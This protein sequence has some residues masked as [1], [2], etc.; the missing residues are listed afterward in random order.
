MS[1]T[2]YTLH[3]WPGIPGRGEFVR[4]AFEASG[5]PYTEDLGVPSLQAHLL[6]TA[7]TGAP[8]HFAP[9]LLEI[10]HG[11]AGSGGGAPPARRGAT[12]AAKARKTDAGQSAGAGAAA[13]ADA[14]AGAGEDAPRAHAFVSQTPAI[15]ALVGPWLGL[16]GD[17]DG[18]DAFA[19]EVRR[20]Q[21]GQLVCT[22]LDLT[23]EAH[24]VRARSTLY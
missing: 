11:G 18:E 6:S 24:D 19:R 15:L 1:N 14:G 21:V 16:A 2:S 20:A 5:T 13:D 23:N 7:A 12:R 4:L 9:P 3:Y 22:A 8:P 17:V 10:V